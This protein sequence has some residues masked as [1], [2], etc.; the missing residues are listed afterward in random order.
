MQHVLT[1]NGP[2][3]L[4]VLCVL[5]VSVLKKRNREFSESWWGKLGGLWG[6]Y[7]DVAKKNS[8]FAL[9]I[10]IERFCETWALFSKNTMSV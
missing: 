4:R 1:P 2:Q 5:S 6:E 9:V 8:T 3:K 7:L 10:Q